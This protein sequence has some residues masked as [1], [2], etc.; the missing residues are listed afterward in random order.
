MADCLTTCISAN[1]QRS[2]YAVTKIPTCN[3]AGLTTH[4]VAAKI[5]RQINSAQF[6]I[7]YTSRFDEPRYYSGD[8]AN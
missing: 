8:T 4:V 7:K 2:G 6:E 5:N 3:A 1:P